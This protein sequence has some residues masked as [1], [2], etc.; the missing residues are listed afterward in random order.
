MLV[1]TRRRTA[2]RLGWTL[3][4]GFFLKPNVFLK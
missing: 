1:D 3:I 2:T 4:L